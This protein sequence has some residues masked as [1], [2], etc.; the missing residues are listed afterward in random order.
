MAITKTTMV[1]IKENYNKLFAKSKGQGIFWLMI[2]PT[3]IIVIALAYVPMFGVIVAFKEYNYG[4][5]ILFS[6]FNGFKNFEFFF[7]SGKAL[8]ITLNTLSY[9]IVFIV[10]G[11]ISSIT[12]AIMI[13]EIG[14]KYFKK[15]TQSVIFLPSFM[16][17]VIISTIFYNF[18]NIDYG[19]L[20]TFLRSIGQP[21][22]E[23][24]TN[25][26]IWRLILPTMKIWK[27]AGF[28]S[29][30]Y[31]AAIM[32]IDQEC[33]ESAEIDGANIF[34]KT[35]HI[36]IPMLVPTIVVLTLLSLGGIMR[37]DFDMFY[38]LVGNNGMLFTTTDVIDTYVFRSL[39]QSHDIGMA[40]AAGLYQSIFCFIFIV[41]ANKIVKIA[42]P[43]YSLF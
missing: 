30:V 1:S 3:I 11:T 5:G 20:N 15:F 13:S 34:H 38:Q 33:Y 35:W 22:Y 18:M 29:I 6:P 2:L 17:W 16:S 27:T 32:G 43:E 41:A 40:S 4:G 31:F 28:G 24:Y 25:T 26:D 36:T 14:G 23:V 7:N 12:L 9:N 19:V 39:I 42:K 37:G 10:T 8:L 21:P